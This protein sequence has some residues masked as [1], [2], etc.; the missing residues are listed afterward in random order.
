MKK[1]DNSD[2]KS[3]LF[4]LVRKYDSTTTST[5]SEFLYDFL[6]DLKHI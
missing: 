6:Y 5:H 2:M 4:Q 1:Q 3:T